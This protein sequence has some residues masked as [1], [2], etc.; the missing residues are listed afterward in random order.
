MLKDVHATASRSK[1]AL[2]ELQLLK[3]KVHDAERQ[4]REGHMVGGL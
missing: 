4:V 3:A 2:G 1:Q